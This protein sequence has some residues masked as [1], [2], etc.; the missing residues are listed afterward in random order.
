MLNAEAFAL[1]LEMFPPEE[2]TMLRRSAESA[3]RA[4]YEIRLYTGKALTLQTDAGIRFCL[5][6]GGA[7]SFMSGGVFVPDARLAAAVVSLAAQNAMF[8]HERE[9]KNAYLTKNGCR[10]GVCGFSPTG[11]LLDEGISSVNIRVPC[12][13]GDAAPDP[14]CKDLLRETRGLLAAGP[15]GC[16][17]TTFLKHCAAILCGEEMGWRRVSVIDERDEFRYEAAVNGQIV[18][19]DV[20]RGMDKAH[21]IQTALRL[22]SPE[23]ILCDEI[24]GEAETAGMLEGMNSGVRFI[25]SMHAADRWELGQRRQFRMLWEEGVFEHVVFLSGVHKG[26]ITEIVRRGEGSL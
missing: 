13:A 19:L 16:G 1:A 21:G 4:I 24:G 25:A 11:A 12:T 9:L 7:A 10:V 18:T 15:P 6:D 8:L 3:D 26:L 17:K 22:F 14:R 5:R 20:L 23:Y 2:A